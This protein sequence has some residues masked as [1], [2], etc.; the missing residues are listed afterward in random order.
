LKQ[1]SVDGFSGDHAIFDPGL[2]LRALNGR[3]D[4]VSLVT[5]GAL[6]C[7]LAHHDALRVAYSPLM[8][9]DVEKPLVDAWTATEV[10][11]IARRTAEAASS[12][13]RSRH[14]SLDAGHPSRAVTTVQRDAKLRS[15]ASTPTPADVTYHHW[16][17]EELGSR[18]NRYPTPPIRPTVS[19]ITPVYSGTDASLFAELAASLRAQTTPMHEWIIGVDGDIG[20]DLQSIIDVLASDV[21]ARV[22]TAGGVKGGILR[23]MQ[24]CLEECSGDYVVPVDADD[25]LTQDA[26]SILTSVAASEGLPD[27]LHSDEDVLDGEHHRDP[28]VRPR[29]DPVLHLAGSY[30]WHALCIKR[31]TAV[32][33][34][35]YDDPMFEWCHDWDTVE[36]IRRIDGHVVHV[37]EVVY[38]WRR[39][40]GSSTNTD[41]PQT[42]QQE[43]VKALFTRMAHDTGHPERYE[44]AEFPLWR[45]ATEFHLRRRHVD[46]PHITMVTL[47]PM[48]DWCRTSLVNADMPILAGVVTGPASD[49]PTGELTRLVGDVGT[50]LVL[51]VDGGLLVADDDPVWE[52]VK[53]FEL[54]ADTAAVCGR[55][56][57]PDGSIVRGAEIADPGS[58]D[59]VFRPL[60]GWLASDPGPYALAL[61]PHSIDVFEPRFALAD[62]QQLLHALRRTDP[63]TRISDSGPVLGRL[64][65]EAG[66]RVVYSPLLTAL[67]T[68]VVRPPTLEPANPSMVGLGP[69]SISRRRFA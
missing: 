63:A 25:L 1:H 4:E 66:R 51:L 19:I 16:L 5:I 62:R 18:A 56:L 39:H 23:T 20:D 55:L 9:A 69:L 67:T 52:A 61:K 22:R 60:A 8:R 41:V 47:G 42:A 49:E 33:V 36:R 45:G 10:A 43:S 15:L 50:D 31:S 3:P 54:L 30:V 40:S 48:S 46:P 21:T 57:A 32:E 27:L 7:L 59:G 13:S 68:S 2:V 24:S 38:H 44:V 34:G 58:P 17:A 6:C 28:F 26:L 11:V 65:F 14:L 37:P 12:R 35:L 64:L 29:W 53:W